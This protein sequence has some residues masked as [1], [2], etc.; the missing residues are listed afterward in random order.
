[1]CGNELVV[2]YEDGL[3]CSELPGWTIHPECAA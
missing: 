3:E 2:K 1:M